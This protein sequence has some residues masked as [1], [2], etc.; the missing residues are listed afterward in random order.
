MNVLGTK[1]GH[2]RDRTSLREAV[3]GSFIE[4]AR[5]TVRGGSI[6]LERGEGD[7][8]GGRKESIGRS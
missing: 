2:Q 8:E 4:V 6:R 7:S 5:I 1:E 3:G